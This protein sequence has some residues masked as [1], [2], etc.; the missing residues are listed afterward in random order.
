MPSFP[1]QMLYLKQMDL[2]SAFHNNWLNS[3]NPKHSTTNQQHIIFYYDAS[4]KFISRCVYFLIFCLGDILLI[5]IW[6]NDHTLGL[7][8]DRPRSQSAKAIS[9]L[10]DCTDH[11]R[12]N[13]FDVIATADCLQS[14]GIARTLIHMNKQTDHHR[15][16]R[17]TVKKPLLFLQQHIHHSLSL[18][19]CLQAF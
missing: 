5:T 15:V 11:R 2:F 13:V 3:N 7:R 6:H 14:G 16:G 8:Q 12:M 10:A 17:A 9:R 19:K 4:T 1:K 18:A